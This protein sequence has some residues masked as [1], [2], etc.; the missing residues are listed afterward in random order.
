[1]DEQ[2]SIPAAAPP[3]PPATPLQA[4]FMIVVLI[5]IIVAYYILGTRIGVQALFMGFLFSTY[6][7]AVRLLAVPDYLP[8]VFGGLVG[9]L[10]A[11]LLFTLPTLLG[12][13][14]LLLGITASIVPIY[15]MIRQKAQLFLNPAFIV[16]LTVATIPALGK[17]QT[18][19]LDMAVGMLF[20]AVYARVIVFVLAKLAAMRQP[21]AEPAVPLPGSA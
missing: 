20:G 16:F 19:F 5:P 7:G 4:L 14:G 17:Q 3:P 18:D 21:R 11:Y 13:P 12:L 15:F 8:T 2:S 9:I 1:M 10:I 6:W